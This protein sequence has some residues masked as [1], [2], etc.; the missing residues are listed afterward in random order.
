MKS[1]EGFAFYEIKYIKLC[2]NDIYI[3]GFCIPK[4]QAFRN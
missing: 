3:Y 1:I 2:S 4:Q